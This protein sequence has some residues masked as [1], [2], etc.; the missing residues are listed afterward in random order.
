MCGSNIFGFC[1]TSML[2]QHA[3]S[4]PELWQFPL[5][6]RAP[7]CGLVRKFWENTK[8]TFV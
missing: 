5:K 8:T 1:E 3:A 7:P 4:Q 6:I 2:E